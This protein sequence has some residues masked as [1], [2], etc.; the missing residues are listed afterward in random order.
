VRHTNCALSL[1]L[2]LVLAACGGAAWGATL[3]IAITFNDL[4]DTP[5]VTP[6][7]VPPDF[8]GLTG[9]RLACNL[10]FPA[11]SLGPA[12]TGAVAVLLEP[13]GENENAT[14]SIS[15]VVALS[16]T[17]GG[18]GAADALTISLQSDTTGI[19]FAPGLATNPRAVVENGTSQ[20]LTARF[21]DPLTG[22]AVN[23]PTG[24]T[25][26]VAS[27]AIPE[28]SSLLLAGS[29]I[30]TGMFMVWRRRRHR[31]GAGG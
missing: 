1:S 29:G 5:T 25:V 26:F 3:P 19:T 6:L 28:P 24:L 27:D 30:V 31:M 17:P 2:G 16:I 12:I 18:G 4:T 23:L 21:F 7:P 15:D 11:G 14:G 13:P 10:T 22:A 20:P 9:E 8:C